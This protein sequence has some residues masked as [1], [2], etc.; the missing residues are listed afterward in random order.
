MDR[1][2]LALALL[3]AAPAAKAAD[4]LFPTD[5]LQNGEIDA[6]LDFTHSTIRLPL[7]GYSVGSE[8]FTADAE[9][10]QLR[11]GTGDDLQFGASVP[12]YSQYRI[13]AVPNY[14]LIADDKGFRDLDVWATYRFLADPAFSLATE[15]RW[16]TDSARYGDDGVELAVTAGSDLGAVQGYGELRYAY[17]RNDDVANTA[18]AKAGLFIPVTASLR[19][20][21]ELFYAHDQSTPDFGSSW[22]C[23]LNLVA[24]LQIAHSVFVSPHAGY[25]LIGPRKS[26][27][28]RF[29]TGQ[30]DRDWSAGLGIYALFGGPDETAAAPAAPAPV[31]TAPSKAPPAAPAPAPVVPE[32]SAL[33]PPPPPPPPPRPVLAVG[34]KITLPH[35]LPLYPRPVGTSVPG[36]TLGAGAIAQLKSRVANASGA[37]W[38]V[39][40]VGQS[41]WVR[42]SDLE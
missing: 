22:S 34:A 26:K 1:R 4:R 15:L 41:G 11:A 10:L 40:C 18:S 32:P 7:S 27:G 12:Y 31:P 38:Y 9:V 35:T 24:H 2:A 20:A 8:E 21:P 5:V 28:P 37:W 30:S 42:E 13:E 36:A 6:S 16:D 33:P 23:G 29:S 25:G 17:R 3:L 19:M 39:D 14:F